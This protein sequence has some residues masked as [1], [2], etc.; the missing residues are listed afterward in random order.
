V[1]D[2]GALQVCIW[3]LQA[4]RKQKPMASLGVNLDHIANAII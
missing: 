2:V 1:V 4:T 3:A